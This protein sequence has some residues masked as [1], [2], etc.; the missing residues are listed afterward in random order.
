MV[1]KSKLKVRN[2][3]ELKHLVA[4]SGLTTK[5]LAESVDVTPSYASSVINGKAYPSPTTAMK[6]T[7]VL[8]VRL[9]RNIMVN[10]IFFDVGVKKNATMKI[11]LAEEVS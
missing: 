7:D 9:R 4:M 2:T 3:R 6:I 11:N 10:D 5:G 8:S 1:T